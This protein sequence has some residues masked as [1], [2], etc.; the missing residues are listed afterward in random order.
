MRE[1]AE[2]FPH[3]AQVVS[4]RIGRRAFLDQ[5]R[6]FSGRIGIDG[7]VE[8]DQGMGGLPLQARGVFGMTPGAGEGSEEGKEREQRGKGG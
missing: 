2:V 8:L 5:A 7:S 4:R 3:Q 1:G 6:D